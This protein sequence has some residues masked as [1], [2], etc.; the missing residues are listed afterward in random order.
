MDS[1]SQSSDP[2]FSGGNGRIKVDYLGTDL[3]LDASLRHKS[4][5]SGTAENAV[6]DAIEQL[7]SAN[8]RAII[9]DI[10]KVQKQYRLNGWATSLLIQAAS[11]VLESGYNERIVMRM[12]LHTQMGYKCT[13]ARTGDNKKLVLLLATDAQLY[14]MP[15]IDISGTTFYDVDKVLGTNSFF[16]CPKLNSKSVNRVG[17]HITQVPTIGNATKQST[18]VN[19]T[20]KLSITADVSEGQMQLYKSYPQCSFDV[21]FN[22]KVNPAFSAPILDKLRSKI[23]G[24][25]ET[26]A[27]SY[28]LQWCQ[29]SFDYATDEEQF[30]Y[31][32]PFF[33]EEMFYYP[34][35]DCEDRSILF[36]YLV[37]NL[38]N[39]RVALLQYPNHIAA[40]VI[41]SGDV[42]GEAV[43]SGGKT[44]TIC[45]PT[46]IGAGIGEAQTVFKNVAP[47]VLNF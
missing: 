42:D 36:S 46:Y 17:M 4:N 44:Y 27:V 26:Q 38:T 29:F 18:H 14:G 1:P 7:S 40:G 2:V 43:I 25:S 13:I 3:Y 8:Y 24:M 9:S 28:L 30:G 31:E 32:K 47:T 20:D 22:A 19:E 12:F 35:N 16:L 39:L 15:Y 6:A 5:L 45:D 33:P 41:F 23:A 34:Q 11:Q 10:T 37:R 21:Y